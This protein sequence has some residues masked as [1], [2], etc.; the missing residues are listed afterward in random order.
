MI[1]TMRSKKRRRP[2]EKQSTGILIVR[3]ET[4]HRIHFIELWISYNKMQE[5]RRKRKDEQTTRKK[6]RR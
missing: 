2:K 4:I 5:E 3:S 1:S 6:R